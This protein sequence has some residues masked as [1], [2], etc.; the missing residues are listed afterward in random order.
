MDTCMQRMHTRNCIR[1]WYSRMEFGD[2]RYDPHCLQL[3]HWLKHPLLVRSFLPSRPGHHHHLLPEALRN[4]SRLP[5]QQG[6]AVGCELIKLAMWTTNDRWLDRYRDRTVFFLIYAHIYIYMHK[7]EII[8]LLEGV[9]GF[10]LVVSV[11]RL[12]SSL[13]V[14]A[15]TPGWCSIDGEQPVRAVS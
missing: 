12:F 1:T 14:K 11:F 2:R 8:F 15:S 13:D 9:E 5:Y 7:C 6:S 4:H 3:E 10:G